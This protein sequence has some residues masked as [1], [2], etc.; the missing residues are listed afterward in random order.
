MSDIHSG[1]NAF[2]VCNVVSGN[3][4]VQKYFVNILPNGMPVYF[5]LHSIVGDDNDRLTVMYITER[6]IIFAYG[7]GGKVYSLKGIFAKSTIIGTSDID[8][9][10]Y[11]RFVVDEKL[12]LWKFEKLNCKSISIIDVHCFPS[13]GGKL[14]NNIRKISKFIHCSCYLFVDIGYILIEGEHILVIAAVCDTPCRYIIVY[15]LL[16]CKMIHHGQPSFKFQVASFKIQKN[17][18][19]FLS[20]FNSEQD[21]TFSRTDD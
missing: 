21:Y 3:D 17:K 20:E 8:F 2:G 6:N 12:V 18:I 19:I 14:Q 9:A 11:N 10:K 15:D 4:I 13:D 7:N 5:Q 16:K 1:P